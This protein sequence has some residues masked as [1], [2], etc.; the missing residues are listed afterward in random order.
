MKIINK[1]IKNPGQYPYQ[2][3]KQKAGLYK[4]EVNL[5]EEYGGSVTAK[6]GRNLYPPACREDARL[7]DW[8][9][10]AKQMRDFY[11]QFVSFL[12]EIQSHRLGTRRDS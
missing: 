2:N 6:I 10:D 11:T 12:E 4:F 1:V 7:D 5:F 8:V 3:F 9:K